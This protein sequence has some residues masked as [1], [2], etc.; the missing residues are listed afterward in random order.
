MSVG[1]WEQRTQVIPK[2]LGDAA[3]A[4]VEQIAETQEGGNEAQTDRL[5]TVT[6][7]AR[8]QFRALDN[9]FPIPRM[10][11]AD[12]DE[13]IDKGV[14]NKYPQGFARFVLWIENSRAEPRRMMYATPRSSEVLEAELA[15]RLS[16]FIFQRGLNEGKLLWRGV[17]RPMAKLE[18]VPHTQRILMS[19]PHSGIVQQR[20]EEQEVE[21]GLGEFRLFTKHLTEAKDD[22]G[23][24]EEIVIRKRFRAERAGAS[25]ERFEV[26]KDEA[27]RRG[28]AFVRKELDEGKL[29]QFLR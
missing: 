13:R 6:Y 8:A 4:H 7:L 5:A 23:R 27:E 19:H 14:A 24:V 12:V 28:V 2:Q 26:L 20:G 1:K 25:G 18:I 9:T 10:G 22:A 3:F 15:E 29:P 17:F 11:D 21:F 16:C